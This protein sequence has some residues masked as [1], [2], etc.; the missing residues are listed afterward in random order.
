MVD[1]SLITAVLS[2]IS[3]FILFITSFTILVFDNTVTDTG[4]IEGP[5]IILEIVMD[6]LMYR[7]IV[8]RDSD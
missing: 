7:I 1:G 3:F 5:Q 8:I 2:L 4:P 6:I